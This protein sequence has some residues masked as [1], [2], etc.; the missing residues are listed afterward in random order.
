MGI[1][2]DIK[3]EVFKPFFT[4]NEKNSGLGLN[5][6]YTIVTDE[7]NGNINI[8]TKEEGLGFKIIIPLESI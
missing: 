4:T 1:R 3:D 2:K 8:C 5:I 6:I 7:L